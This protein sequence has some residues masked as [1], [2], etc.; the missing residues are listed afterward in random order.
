MQT[1]FSL[2]PDSRTLT[3]RLAAALNGNGG[4]GLRILER[5]RPRFMSTFPNEI[6]TCRVARGE[7]RRL[8]CKYE[9]GRE[10]PS[11]GHRGGLAYEAEIYRRVLAPLKTSCP[12]FI[13][14]DADAANGGTWLVLEHL[15]RCTR[16]KDIRV[17]R[18]GTRQPEAVMLAA[19]WLGQFHAAP[20]PVTAGES[21][22]FLKHYDGGYYA[23]WV[24]R[25]FE[26]SRPLHKRF[27][28]L[29][30]LCRRG[31][32]MFK[33]LLAAPPTVIHGEFYT[34]NILVRGKKV[35]PVD[36]ES[37]AVAAG[38][39]DLA[40]LTEGHW[41]E[42]LKRRCERE[43]QISRWPGGA[44]GAFTRTL[45]TARLY[46]QF[47]WLGEQPDCTLREANRWRFAEL[48]SVAKR[49]QLIPPGRS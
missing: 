19:R 41:R 9:A 49:L 27:P 39:I 33:P 4:S 46:L 12:E 37:A 5:K 48:H 34:N 21:R 13:G 3:A 16:L 28:W 26:F 10:H 43:Y 47:R 17:R 2:L 8:F 44:P 32:E 42:P 45:D 38:E 22:S 30:E 11:H 29:P 36:W 7:P 14:S 35:F 23:G 6:V 24:R 20:P 1:P 25:T 40:A 15:N 18:I 31:R